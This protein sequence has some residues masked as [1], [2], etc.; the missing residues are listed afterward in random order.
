MRREGAA[1]RD[2]L[3]PTSS[4]RTGSD[5]LKPALEFGISVEIQAE[6]IVG[7]GP[8][9]GGDV[10]DRIGVAGE[11]FAALQPLVQD[12]EQTCGLVPVA[13]DR[14]K[15]LLRGPEEEDQL[16]RHRPEAC[17]L[18]E[19]PLHRV[20]PTA[21]VRRHQPSGLLDEIEQDRAG[22]EQAD[23]LAAADGIVVDDRRDLV[24]RRFLEKI[25]F[26]LLVLD[27]VH[28]NDLIRQPGLLQEHR[29]LVAV[30]CGPVVKID[31]CRSG[32][33]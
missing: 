18:P 32:W 31:H 21:D 4:R 14:K 24:V 17:D 11:P 13:V 28:G 12:S 25:R 7:R 20:H 1:R 27:E 15:D 16:A 29:D 10:R 33:F 6:Q 22:F 2:R 19:Q 23:R 5:R 3:P 9:I 26:E 8:A 30:R